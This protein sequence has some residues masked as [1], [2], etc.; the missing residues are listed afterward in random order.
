MNVPGAGGWEG[1]RRVDGAPVL[2]DVLALA[3]LKDELVAAT[4]CRDC[5][6]EDMVLV[7]KKG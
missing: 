1:S 3:V 5:G 7:E 6:S 2:V 4:G